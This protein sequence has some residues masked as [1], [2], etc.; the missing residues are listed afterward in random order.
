MDQN[1]FSAADQHL[2]R[3][4]EEVEQLLSAEACKA[5]KEELV[6]FG[7]DIGERYSIG[8]DFV[9]H[10]FDREK[11]RSMPVLTTG[12]STSEGAEPYR[13][14]RD[15]TPQRY[16]TDDEIQVVPHD[17]CPSCWGEWDFKFEHRQCGSCGV[18]LGEGVKILLDSDVCPNCEQGTVSAASPQCEE[19]GFVV[20]PKLV[21][22]G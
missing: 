18:V 15:S 10:V 14:W 11:E 8:M 7:R 9:V 19:C 6:A 1:A 17:R 3:I 22:W 4:S 13:T 21:V 5:L 12:L 20:D 2:D 16:V